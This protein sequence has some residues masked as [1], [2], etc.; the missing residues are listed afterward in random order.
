MPDW[1]FLRFNYR[2]FLLV[3]GIAPIVHANSVRQLL[4]MLLRLWVQIP[5]KCVR[6]N[7]CHYS[8]PAL[9]IA[10]LFSLSFVCSM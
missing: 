6:K 9:N 5:A 4:K 7:A 10:F 8:F 2:C 1:I 3:I